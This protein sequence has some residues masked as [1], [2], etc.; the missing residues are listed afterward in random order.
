MLSCPP[1]KLM[2]CALLYEGPCYSQTIASFQETKH[3]INSDH[4]ILHIETKQNKIK[5]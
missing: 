2:L 3:K 1:N 4:M 5:A